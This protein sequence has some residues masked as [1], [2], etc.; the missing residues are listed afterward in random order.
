VDYDKQEG[1]CV[2]YTY[3]LRP[4]I[5]EKRVPLTLYKFY[6]HPSEINLSLKSEKSSINWYFEDYTSYNYWRR[7]F[8]NQ[9]LDSQKIDLTYYFL[10]N[11]G[12][13]LGFL[14][15]KLNYFGKWEDDEGVWHGGKWNSDGNERYYTVGINQFISENLKISIFHTRLNRDW[16]YLLSERTIEVPPKWANYTADR[17]SMGYSNRLD[18][19]YLFK[20]KWGLELAFDFLQENIKS[21]GSVNA[22]WGGP[23]VHPDGT[24]DE[25]KKGQRGKLGVDFFVS[26][27]FTLSL[28]YSVEH[29]N[30]GREYLSGKEMRSCKDVQTWNFNSCYYLNEN[31]GLDLNY[32][33]SY[34][35]RDDKWVYPD[36]TNSERKSKGSQYSLILGFWVRN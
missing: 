7:E 35:E 34:P 5:S 3:Y 23:K 1:F 2:S 16:N 30:L 15:N 31:L 22:S 4:L 13:E 24:Y 18:A 19:Y 21:D 29:L 27:N 32:I 12:I 8:Q 10:K 9:K 17:K 14:Y 20:D 28:G 6:E 33:Y 26:R 36:G 11:T 25:E